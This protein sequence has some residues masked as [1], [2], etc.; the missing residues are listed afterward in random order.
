M[1]KKAS[2]Q[3][4]FILAYYGQASGAKHV[5]IYLL[6]YVGSEGSEQT[7]I[8]VGPSCYPCSSSLPNQSN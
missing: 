1:I 3:G 6:K 7:G 4:T 2:R 5:L 8:S